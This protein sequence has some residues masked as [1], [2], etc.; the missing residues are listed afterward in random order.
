MNILHKPASLMQRRALFVTFAVP[1][2]P[3]ISANG[4]H[5]RQRLLIDAIKAT[6]ADIEVLFYVQPELDDRDESLRL[7]I[8]SRLNDLWEGR[9]RVTLCTRE[10]IRPERISWWQRYL[11]PALSFFRQSA[12][13]SFSG[14][15]QVVAFE[16][17]LSRKPDFI[18]VHRLMCMP[19][20]FLSR[21]KLPP[22]FLDLDDIEHVAFARSIAQPPNWAS[23]RLEYL[24]LP[25][26]MN[27]E[28]QAIHRCANT[29]VCSE[30][31]RDKLKKVFRTSKVVAVPNAIALRPQRDSLT[32]KK[33][34]L[35]LG[36]YRYGPNRIGAEFFIEKIWPRIVDIVPE[37]RITIAGVRSDLIRQASAPPQ[38]IDFPGFLP[39]LDAAYAGARVVVCPI[40]SGGGTRVK[41]MEA[42]AYGKP[43]VATTIGAEGIDLLNDSEIFLRD[44]PDEYADACIELLQ[45]HAKALETGRRAARAI[46][47]RYDRSAVV[48]SLA[49]VLNESISP[50]QSDEISPNLI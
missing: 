7:E 27:A 43:V 14:P 34:L 39:D 10:A 32:D 4:F 38:G 50:S 15:D 26:L 36:D 35:L 44:R 45:N 28:R 18:F 24:Q 13:F 21:L 17:C 9:F 3:G 11:L 48:S 25:A 30:H 42:A 2:N 16:D 20:V 22:V 47:I 6:N 23:K 41:I 29:F 12:Y 31:D 33:S 46:E 1:E 37:A 40:L 8:E 49:G 5:R 19:P